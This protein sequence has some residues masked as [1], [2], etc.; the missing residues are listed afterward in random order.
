MNRDTL[1]AL[2]AK[3]NLTHALRAYFQTPE[4]IQALADAPNIAT[5]GVP[6]RMTEDEAIAALVDEAGAFPVVPTPPALRKSPK[7]ETP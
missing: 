7:T 5:S 1:A 2:A 4:G 6:H 3:P